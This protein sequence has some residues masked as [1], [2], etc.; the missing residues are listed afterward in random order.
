MVLNVGLLGKAKIN[1][2]PGK[3]CKFK[4]FNEMF[5]SDEWFIEKLANSYQM[6]V[7]QSRTP[8]WYSSQIA[9]YW[10]RFQY[11]TTA[12]I[13]LITVKVSFIIH[14]NQVH[15]TIKIKFCRILKILIQEGK[16]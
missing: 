4:L 13:D 9:G 3:K 11:S 1:F 15:D 12:T 16:S 8:W 6:P 14:W 7:V 10:K 2:N 5:L